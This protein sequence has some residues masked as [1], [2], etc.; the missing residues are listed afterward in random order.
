[1]EVT[2][3]ESLHRAVHIY[4]HT[5]DATEDDDHRYM[6][7]SATFNKECRMLARD[8]LGT[9]HIRIRIGRPGSSHLNVEQQVFHNTMMVAASPPTDCN[10]RS[11]T[12]RTL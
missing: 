7:F 4:L 10:I 1:M 3:I 12:L 11:S 9:N 5:E 2:S 6:M 8:Y